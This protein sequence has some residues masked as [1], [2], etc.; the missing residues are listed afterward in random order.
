MLREYHNIQLI[1]LYLC[2]FLYIMF[3]SCNHMTFFEVTYRIY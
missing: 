3:F 2:N 1:L